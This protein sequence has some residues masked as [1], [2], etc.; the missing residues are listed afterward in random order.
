MAEPAEVSQTLEHFSEVVEVNDLIRALPAAC[1]DVIAQES[2]CER[3]TG[4]NTRAFSSVIRR[5]LN[6]RF[7]HSVIL[8]RYQEQPHLLDPHLG[9]VSVED[10]QPDWTA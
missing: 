6:S 10:P 3:F 8:D 2:L 4:R 1:T 7:S 9:M 5:L